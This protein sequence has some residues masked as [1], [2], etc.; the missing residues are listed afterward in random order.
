MADNSALDPVVLL[1][2]ALPCIVITL[3]FYY[4]GGISGLLVDLISFV[5]DVRRDL[6]RSTPV[7]FVNNPSYCRTRAFPILSIRSA[8][9]IQCYR[10]VAHCSCCSYSWFSFLPRSFSSDL[11]LGPLSNNQP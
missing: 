1:I 3:H 8:P 2:L 7:A 11:P 6:F 9:E 5:I 4:R 10:L